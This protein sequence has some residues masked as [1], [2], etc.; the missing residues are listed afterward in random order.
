MIEEQAAP[1][2]RRKTLGEAPHVHESSRI[3]RSE[4]GSWTDI[5]PN[6]SISE[7]VIGDYTYMAGD[8]SIIYSEVGIAACSSGVSSSGGQASLSGVNQ[9]SSG[10]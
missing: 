6:T 3:G 5:G 8:N 1:A 2:V 7:S 10:W 9:R 4:L